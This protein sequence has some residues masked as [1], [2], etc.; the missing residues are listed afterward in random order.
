VTG[1]SFGGGVARNDEEEIKWWRS[2]DSGIEFCIAP[3]CIKVDILV[4]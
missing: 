3:V 4:E 2:H 1:L